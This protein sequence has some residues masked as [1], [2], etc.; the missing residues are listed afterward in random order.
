MPTIVYL[1][2]FRSSPGSAKAVGLGAA[3]AALPPTIRP[4]LIVPELTHRPA[5]AMA[6][7]DRTRTNTASRSPS[8]SWVSS[9]AHCRPTEPHAVPA[10]RGKLRTII[11]RENSS[12]GTTTTTQ[13]LTTAR[14]H[15]LSTLASGS[16]QCR[17]SRPTRVGLIRW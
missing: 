13:V 10:T 14:A 3:V 11:T 12:N 16:F 4:A 8:P 17:G 2:G 5:Q 1:H 7:I 9:R 15:G 6:T